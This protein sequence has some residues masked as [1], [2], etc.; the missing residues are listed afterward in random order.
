MQPP[1]ALA[2]SQR[3]R[4]YAREHE[5]HHHKA[6]RNPGSSIVHGAPMPADTADNPTLTQIDCAQ[7]PFAD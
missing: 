3:H 4:Q 6:P 7:A 1:S 2:D 5:R